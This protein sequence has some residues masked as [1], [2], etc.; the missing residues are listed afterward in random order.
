MDEERQGTKATTRT[1]AKG[2]R[3][4]KQR[5]RTRLEEH[6]VLREGRLTDAVNIREDTM[7]VEMGISYNN[8]K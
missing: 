1:G 2:V 4:R 8:V 3:R 6:E 5:R 7:R